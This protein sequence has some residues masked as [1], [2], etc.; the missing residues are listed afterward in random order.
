M[1]LVVLVFLLATQAQ[2]DYTAAVLQMP[3][4]GRGLNDTYIDVQMKNLRLIEAYASVAKDLGAQI[5]VTP[6]LGLGAYVNA[7]N[8][9][10]EG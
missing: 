1:L 4:A 9:R 3:K 5:L 10:N 8:E 2:G 7:K 6:E